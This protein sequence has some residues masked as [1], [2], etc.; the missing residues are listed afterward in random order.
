MFR[1]LIWK[2]LALMRL[3]T[4]MQLNLIIAG[5]KMVIFPL[6]CNL[7]TRA[8]YY[9]KCVSILSNNLYE[10]NEMVKHCVSSVLDISFLVTCSQLIQ[11]SLPLSMIIYSS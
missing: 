11:C 4:L 3:I 1:E 6:L 7:V 10:H 8:H 9:Y 2:P 5:I